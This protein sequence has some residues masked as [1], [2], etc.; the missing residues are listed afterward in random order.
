MAIFG[1]K[2]SDE[3][4]QDETP[5]PGAD[6]AVEHS[7]EKAKRFFDRA[8]T[9]HE[10]GQYEY[11]MSL[12]LDGLKWDPTD[13]GAIE[14]FALSAS[15]FNNSKTKPSKETVRNIEGKRLVDRYALALLQWGVKP[16]DASSVVKA[17]EAAAKIDAESALNMSEVVYWIGERALAIIRSDKPKK[18]HYVKLMNACRTARVYDLAVAA[19]DEGVRL[20][21]TDS[22]LAADTRNLAAQATMSTGGYAGTGE[23]GGFRANIKDAN[24]QRLV[25]ERERIVK[26]EDVKDRLVSVAEQEYARRP[27]DLPTVRQYVKALKERGREDDEKLAYRLLMKAYEET[28]QFQLKVDAD[29]IRLRQA[30]RALMKYRDAAEENPD[31][32]QARENFKKAERK[33][34]EMEVETLRAQVEAYPTDLRL[35][36]ELGKRELKLD[37]HDEAIALFQE[38]QDDPKYRASSLALLGESFFRQDWVDEAIDTYRRALDGH[39][40]TKDSS[41]LDLRYGLML[42]L[43]RKAREEND[44]EAASE[45]EKL[46]S[47]I[48]IQQINYRD[49]KD[50][51]NELKQLVGELKQRQAG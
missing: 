32:T 14:K 33:F 28:K 42:A 49:I 11:A 20:D 19:G 23:A 26:T 8:K 21:P 47:G 24:Q 38:S 18:D 13:L 15:A 22:N 9:V 35:K 6:L 3:E 29:D 44:L 31:H 43:Q 4:Q 17:A 37:N 12:W 5:Q 16:R 30:R 1:K 7:P 39:E 48:A 27:D 51:R 2:K 36:F 46:A 40:D 45:A 50:R 25:E 41:G 34:I 10:S